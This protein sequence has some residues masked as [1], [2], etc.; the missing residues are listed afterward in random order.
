MN[1]EHEWA[2]YT[3]TDEFGDTYYTGWTC[4]DCDDEGYAVGAEVHEITEPEPCD[5]DEY[6]AIG[7]AGALW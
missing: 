6:V 1:H 2:E 3:L 4:M 7:A 5:C